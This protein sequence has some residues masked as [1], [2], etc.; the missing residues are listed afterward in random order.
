MCTCMKAAEYFLSL[1]TEDA[2]DAI[3]NMKLQKLLYY[4]QGF[5]LAILGKPLFN[6]DFEAWEYGPVIRKIYEEYRSYGD[7]ALPKPENFTFDPYSEE[8]KKL[9][10]EIYDAFGQYS[11]WA[12][13]EMTHQTAPWRN[14]ARNGIISKESMKDYFLTQVV[15][16]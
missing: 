6:E 8:E 2:G 13:S 15:N 9:F 12:L 14:A 11:A 16:E 3:S 7:K 5:S 10:D 1:Q 4:A